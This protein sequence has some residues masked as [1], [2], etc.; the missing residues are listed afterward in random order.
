MRLREF[1]DG[2]G[3]AEDGAVEDDEV[4]G[5]ALDVFEEVGG[6]QD[7]AVGVAGDVE[8]GFEKGAAGDGIEAEGG[9]VEDE[10]FGL[11]GEGECEV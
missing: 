2:A 9:V 7:G 10:E 3:G 6:D 11:W 5:D 1:F 4:I 8:D